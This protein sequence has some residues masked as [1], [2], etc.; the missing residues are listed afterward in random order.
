MNFDN[1]SVGADGDARASQRDNHVVL[2]R[3]MRWIDDDRQMRDAAN[4]GNRREVEGVA[5]VLRE[6]AH[7]ALAEHHIVIALRHDVF[8]GEQPLIQRRG[9]AALQQHGQM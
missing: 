6:R 4:R 7:A 2:A 3:A 9:Q 8:R 5:R 1:Q